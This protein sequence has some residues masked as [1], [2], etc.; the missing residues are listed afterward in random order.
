MLHPNGYRVTLAHDYGGGGHYP[1]GER[2]APMQVGGRALVI[3]FEIAPLTP[4]GITFQ[5][6]DMIT[7]ENVTSKLNQRQR[8]SVEG[9]CRTVAPMI[10]AAREAHATE[11]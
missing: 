5:A 7:S 3:E 2:V 9:H 11:Q 6:V 10:K 1:G 4:G 8:E